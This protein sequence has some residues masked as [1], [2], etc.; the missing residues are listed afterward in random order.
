MVQLPVRESD[1]SNIQ[2]KKQNKTLE[3]F[4]SCFRETEMLKI[5]KIQ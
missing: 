3:T 2:A 1:F 5:I 4:Q